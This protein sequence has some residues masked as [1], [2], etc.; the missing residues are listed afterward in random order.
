M[1]RWI[2][3]H[4]EQLAQAAAGL[5]ALLCVLVGLLRAPR[6]GR[7]DALLHLA[8]RLSALTFSDAPGTLK[9]PGA[10]QPQHQP[11]LIP[12]PPRP[13]PRPPDP[14]PD[15]VP[16]PADPPEDTRPWPPPV[17]TLVPRG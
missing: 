3:Q 6:G 4:Q 13:R 9:V 5:Y 8:G 15:P 1:T 7:L 16:E 2:L 14:E 10:A 17:S 12:T 11:P